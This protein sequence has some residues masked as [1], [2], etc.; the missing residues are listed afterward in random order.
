M[1][2]EYDNDFET[3]DVF[4]DGE[5]CAAGGTY[6]G[7]WADCLKQAKDDGFIIQQTDGEWKHF[8]EDCVR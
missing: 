4:C 3:M 1:A 5:N 8:C 6:D 7:S 2:I